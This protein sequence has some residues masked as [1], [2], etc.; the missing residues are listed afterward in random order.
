MS[1]PTIALS[2][3]DLSIDDVVRVAR[4]PETRIVLRSDAHGH[5]GD[6]GEDQGATALH[7]ATANR[8]P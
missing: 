4:S 7:R 6:E 5:E 2:G 1:A 3:Q 8:H